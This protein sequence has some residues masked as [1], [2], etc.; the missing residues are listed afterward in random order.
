[1]R[2]VLPTADPYAHTSDD[3]AAV[4]FSTVPSG[5]LQLVWLQHPRLETRMDSLWHAQ[6][7]AVHQAFRTVT[8][9]QT[10]LSPTAKEITATSGSHPLT[11]GHTLHFAHDP[12]TVDQPPPPQH[13]CY[14][15]RQ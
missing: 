5:G 9:A 7:T 8:E 4:A 6:Q 12:A 1:M 11:A 15:T 14:G 3:R 2:A 13:C 10:A